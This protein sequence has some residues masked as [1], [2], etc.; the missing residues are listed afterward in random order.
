MVTGG[1]GFIGSHLVDAL[2]SRGEYVYVFDNLS[3]GSLENVKHWL[4]NRKFNFIKGNLLSPTDLE[5][6]KIEH[7]SII[8]HLAA[9]PEVRL[10][11][12]VTLQV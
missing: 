12:N 8:F 6:L 1:A 9:N 11:S 3:T 2:M 10:G 5:K 7:Y 4:G